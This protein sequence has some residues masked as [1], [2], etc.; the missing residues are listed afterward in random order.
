MSV[1]MSPDHGRSLPCL[2]LSV[3]AFGCSRSQPATEPVHDPPVAAMQE[4]AGADACTSCHP[5]QARLWADSVH[6]RHGIALAEPEGGADA[7]V[8]AGWMQTY[9]RRSAS[10]LHQV[11]PLAFDLREYRWRDV[12]EVMEA[13]AGRPS[14]SQEFGTTGLVFEFKCGGCHRSQPHV[15][16]DPRAQRFESTWV[17]ASINCESCHGPARYHVDAWRRLERPAPL[18]RLDA[19]G[20][21]AFTAICA[22]CHGSPAPVGDYRPSDTKDFVILL[23]DGPSLFPDGRAKGQVYQ[24]RGHLASPCFLE[25]GATC[26]S[27]HDSHSLEPVGADVADGSCLPC[28]GE[29]ATVDH[30][31]HV[32]WRGAGARC[33]ECHMPRILG[34]LMDHQREHRIA[35]PMP[36]LP[37]P[38]ACTVCHDDKDKAWS[39]AATEAWWGRPP[40]ATLQAIEA[41]RRARTNPRAAAP[42]L[43]TA[44]ASPDPFIRGNAIVYLQDPAAALDDPSPE[45]RYLAA[46]SAAPRDAAGDLILEKFLDDPEAFVRVVAAIRLQERGRTIPRSMQS[47]LESFVRHYSNATQVRTT[48]GEWQLESGDHAVALDNYSA[49][50]ARSPHEA[51]G[52]QGLAAALDG[53]GRKDEATAAMV[54]WAELAVT[55]H[56]RA[57]RT[58]DAL[59]TLRQAIDAAPPGDARRE[60]E[61]YLALVGG[62]EAER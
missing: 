20:P 1:T 61:G 5:E 34:G 28:H 25:G 3:L 19:L 46:R 9:L 44:L 26:A 57:G 35:N 31:H 8:G 36:W 40:P 60:L 13:I 7:A 22:R 11:A 27:C 15:A 51:T 42:G 30:T 29:L 62:A 38:D 4:Y 23:E 49:L 56:V 39:I 58:E 2:L 47:D 53:L 6:G 50:V 16:V 37:E 55:S 45:V 21:R 41:I 32:N 33:I 52:W 54:R 24:A 18:T 48:L 59:K 43:R 10:G 12:S 17:D 14:D